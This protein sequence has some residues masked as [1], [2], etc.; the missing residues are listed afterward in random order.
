MDWACWSCFLFTDSALLKVIYLKL[1]KNR[2]YCLTSS[3]Y[4]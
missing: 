1:S 4:H 3:S 2:S